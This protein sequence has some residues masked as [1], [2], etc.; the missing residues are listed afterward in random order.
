MRIGIDASFI[1]TQ[2][3]TGLAVYTWNIVNELARLHDDIVLW[4][5]DDFG[6]NISSDRIRKV[7]KAWSFLGEQRFMIR[8]FWM[9]LVLPYLVR[10]EKVDVLFSTV[11][12]GVSRCPVPHVITVH[13]IIPLTFPVDHPRSVQWNFKHRFPVFLNNAAAVIADSEYTKQDMI[14]HYGIA[15]S[16]IHVVPL[17]YDNSNFFPVEA[18]LT[19]EKYGLSRGEY[20]VTV[21][22]ATFRKNHETLIE[23][24]GKV[25]DR[26][27][28]KLVF[29]G[30]VSGKQELRLRTL[31]R[32]CG[33][34]D[35]IVFPGYVLYEHLAALYSGAALFVYISL[36]EGFGL[37][38]LE[39]MAC[40]APV[41][42]S[43]TT[44]IPEVAGDAAV[45]V[46]PC[47]S[48]SVAAALVAVIDA[49]QRSAS[50]R[51]AGL[52]RVKQFSWEQT[53]RDTL[54]VLESSIRA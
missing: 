52:E 36:Y 20:I 48:E 30:P 9:E 10:K 35:R 17:G 11:P 14:N 19:L 49:P 29:A 41:V 23:A 18:P 34:E 22:N 31:A 4:T 26:V 13:D 47:D 5:S 7:L 54:A 46:D 3:P 1:G 27:T 6:F 42:A 40:G 12:G 24:L 2:K 32:R 33:I 8:P 37:P 50:L 21:G 53:A 15:D 25:R 51:V 45:L 43:S 44:S 38:V 39:A 28:Q 16:H